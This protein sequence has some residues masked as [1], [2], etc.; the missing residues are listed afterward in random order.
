[1]RTK[2]KL[3]KK[4]PTPPLQIMEENEI[5]EKEELAKFIR[6]EGYHAERLKSLLGVDEETF[7]RLIEQ[8][9]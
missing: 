1:M 8:N 3:K 5:F 4:L 7:E 9:N 2:T 6:Q